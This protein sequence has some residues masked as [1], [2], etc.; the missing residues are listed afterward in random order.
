MA[1]LT[2][3]DFLND[4]NL[5]AIKISSHDLGGFFRKAITIPLNTSGLALFQD[6]TMAVYGE[7]TEVSG[8]FDLV[9]AKR[10]QCT[11]RLAFGDL[12][13]ADGLGLS[14]T[15]SLTLELATSRLDL[16]RDFCRTFF[17]FPGTFSVQDLK[18]QLAP[19]FRRLLGLCAGG[20][21]AS[22]LHRAD[23]STTLVP[24]LQEGLERYLFDAGVRPGRILDLSL[25]SKDLE[26]RNASD[27]RRADEQRRSA[28]V[29]E[30]K[31]ARLRRLAGILK[32]QDV[33]SVLTKVP[34]E[35]LKGLLYAKLMEDDSVQLT[36][37]EL[38]SKAKDCGEEVVQVIY[39]AMEGLLST[40]ASIAPEEITT[41][42]VERIF[43]ATGNKV[44]EL[45]AE[46]GL[47]SRVYTFKDPLRSV[48]SV[49][50]PRGPYLVGGSKHGVS[51]VRLDGTMEVLDYP[52][53]PGGP[54]R[55]GVNSIAMTGDAIYATHSEFGLAR[56][57]ADRPGDEPD[58]VYEELTRRNKT[59]RA[60]QMQEGRLLFASGRHVYSAP[61]DASG[62][63]VKYVSSI[64][65]PVTCV[66][67]AA[68]TIFAGTENGSI[69]CWKVASPDQPVVLVRKREPIVNLRLARI[70]AIPHLI[71]SARDLSVRARVIGQNL[72]T[73]YES[74]GAPIGVLDAASD[75]ICASDGDGR[76]LLLWKST[77]PAK[78]VRAI[79]IWKLSDK[80]VLD[81]WM[82]KTVARSA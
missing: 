23:H 4:R 61:A 56:W 25:V 50:S 71:Y 65:S 46:G 17:N 75:M 57:Q 37:E 66:A 5:L 48:R 13:T 74:D 80:P 20:M 24:R 6:G 8:H 55:G 53:P 1:R 12:K 14:A 63:P 51:T 72:E 39:K 29:F 73:S 77:A 49:E 59:T 11:L 70:C 7:G 27:K 76:R 47:Q 15:T 31:E 16:F 3:S 26:E 33:Q 34:D 64:E 43:A 18:S 32:D 58:M 42:N 41:S 45:D 21:P 19:E 35:K 22:E 62:E 69:V 38:V 52:L 40:G 79:D 28:E 30:K 67:A 68:R 10:G 9:L 60:V 78:P 44:L 82:K 2:L 36:A 81:L 54:I